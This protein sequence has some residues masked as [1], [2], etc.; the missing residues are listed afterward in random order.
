MNDQ[1]CQDLFIKHDESNLRST[2]LILFKLKQVLHVSFIEVADVTTNLKMAEDLLLKDE[3]FM[4]ET[5]VTT[6]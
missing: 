2:L 5:D 3:A 1:G 6:I 4:F